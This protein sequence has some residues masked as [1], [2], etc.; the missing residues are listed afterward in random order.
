M[1]KPGHGSSPSPRRGGMGASPPCV[2]DPL[3]SGVVYLGSCPQPCQPAPSSLRDDHA[4]GRVGGDHP[5]RLAGAL[6]RSS[7]LFT[8]KRK[9]NFST[10]QERAGE[11]KDDSPHRVFKRDQ[12]RSMAKDDS[13]H[14]IFK[15]DQPRS[16]AGCYR[17]SA[18]FC[19]EAESHEEVIEVTK[20]A[21]QFYESTRARLESRV[22]STRRKS[23]LT[24][25]SA[26]RTRSRPKS[27]W[28]LKWRGT[29]VP[30][31]FFEAMATASSRRRRSFSFASSRA[32]PTSFTRMAR[33]ICTSR[34]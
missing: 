9:E 14:R 4:R 28:L 8:R 33:G 13:P 19:F 26:R 34:T 27:W 31:E 23:A 3:P 1:A 32:N 6:G 20:R 22:K 10:Q 11:T 16:M 18:L 17:P 25:L 21:L 29:G 2:P 15:R 12:P 7:F 24:R 30:D 5:H